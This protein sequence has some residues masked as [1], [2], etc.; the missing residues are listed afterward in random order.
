MLIALVLL[1]L[2]ALIGIAA[3]PLLPIKTRDL[4]EGLVGG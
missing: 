2:G 3:F 4:V 1:V